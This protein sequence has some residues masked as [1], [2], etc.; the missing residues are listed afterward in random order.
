VVRFIARI[1]AGLCLEKHR[2][3]KAKGYATS[4]LVEANRVEEEQ[5]CFDAL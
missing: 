4:R 5:D 1:A 2:L 3:L